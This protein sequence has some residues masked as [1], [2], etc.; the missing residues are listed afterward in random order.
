MP[1]WVALANG[2]QM[3]GQSR[4][5]D[6]VVR[7]VKCRH[8]SDVSMSP[9][10][11]NW[12]IFCRVIDNYGDIGICWRLARQLAHEHG[13]RVR[14]WVDDLQ[15]L[16]PLC[17]EVDLA[18]AIQCR[19]G[20]DIV[21][22]IE[23][24][25]VDS[26]GDVIIEAFACELPAPW[27]AAMAAATEKPCWINLEYLTAESWADGCHGMA[28]PHPT[29]PLVKHFF[30]PG[31]SSATGGLLRER[32]LLTMRDAEGTGCVASE[33]LEVSLFCYESAP[34]AAL[35]DIL[36]DSPMPVHLHVAP[37]QPAAAVASKLGSA[38]PWQGGNLSVLPFEFLLQ[39]EYDRLLWRCDVNF[40][41]GEDSFVRAQWAAQ[42]FVW[43]PYRQADDAHLEKLDAFLARYV[44]GMSANCATVAVDLFQAW[45]SKGDLR[46]A[47]HDF[48]AVR[49][50]I[51]SYNRCWAESLAGKPDLADALVK[52]CSSKV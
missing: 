23:P 33:T 27:I 52:F 40:V 22:W 30:F 11:L 36:M 28:S 19:Q 49:S 42:P 5:G 4:T 34:V 32:N 41:R 7:I 21:H 29:L 9:M 18:L 31:F 38:G 35:I 44:A 10:Q 46:Q 6:A 8:G 43:Q 45:N 48:L 26:V 12:D 20:V 13:K 2:E 24:V 50:E 39:D 37:G 16:R 15:S 25:A 51:A 1:M 3:R 14:L 47:W 17:P